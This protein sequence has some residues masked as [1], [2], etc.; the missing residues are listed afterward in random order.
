MIRENITETKFEDLTTLAKKK[1]LMKNN[2]ASTMTAEGDKQAADKPGNLMKGIQDTLRSRVSENV[3][4][5]LS[6]LK[7]SAS[8]TG[9]LSKEMTNEAQ[10]P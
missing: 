8:K 1:V 3:D 6:G 10:S 7:N 2:R 5:L 4:G 9:S